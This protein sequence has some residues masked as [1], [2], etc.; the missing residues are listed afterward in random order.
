M[1]VTIFQEPD[2]ATPLDPDEMEGLKF[3]HITTRGE[4]D[5]LEQ[6]NI[7]EGLQWLS[8]QKSPDIF[9]EA[10]VRELHKKLFGQVWEWAGS[11]RL[12]GK[13]IG[14]DP[15]YIGVELRNALGD[16][17]YWAEHSTFEPLEAATRLHYRLVFI[18]PFPNG[19]GRFS[20]IMGDLMMEKVF[21]LPPINWTAG[22]DLQAAGERRAQYIA[23]L[24][25]ADREEFDLL[26]AFVAE[27][28]D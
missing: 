18:H 21:G 27:G 22:V 9:D 11:F 3:K 1:I 10:F 14:V 6:A 2:G 8:R 20:R 13:N 12:T 25:A 28:E 4:L 26:L 7:Q 15:M 23:A 24:R 16:A 19:N 17:R 5:H